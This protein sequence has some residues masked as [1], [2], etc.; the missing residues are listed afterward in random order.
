[1]EDPFASAPA[2]DEAQAEQPAEETFAAPPAEPEPAPAPAKKAPAKKSAGTLK[3][4]VKPNIL[5]VSEGKV[6]LTFKGGV[7]FDAP[8][9]VIH[10]ADLQDA[11][12]QVSGENAVLLAQVMDR[13]QKAGQH[14]ASQGTS[15]PSKGNGGGGNTRQRSSAPRGATEPPAGAPPCPGPGWVFKSGVS[16][17]GNAWKAWM[18]PQGSDEKPLFF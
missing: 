14:F 3:V 18:P 4:D 11:H 10:A 9:I 2:D 6:V 15:A 5:P 1:M 8:W 16:K 7:G 17:A 13:T 12:D